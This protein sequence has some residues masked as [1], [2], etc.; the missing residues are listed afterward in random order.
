MLH[1]KQRVEK[2]EGYVMF[3]KHLEIYEL[4]NL[5][6]VYMEYFRNPLN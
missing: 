1:S 2:K 4:L 5:L 3:L 6:Y